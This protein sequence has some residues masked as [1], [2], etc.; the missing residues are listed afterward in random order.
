M[1]GAPLIE[2]LKTIKMP[3]NASGTTFAQ[4][5]KGFLPAKIDRGER[6]DN[7]G[8]MRQ[9]SQKWTGEDSNLRRYLSRRRT[10][11]GKTK[12]TDYPRIPFHALRSIQLVSS[13]VVMSIL[14]YFLWYLHHDGYGSPWTFILVS[15][16][17]FSSHVESLTGP[18]QK[19]TAFDRLCTH[20]LLTIGHNCSPHILWA[21]SPSQSVP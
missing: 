18:P 4:R 1:L 2:R 15:F 9:L 11:N 21:Q 20:H 7:P 17:R 19:K 8:L 5:F 14:S 6:G 13:I 10:S 16:P 3:G 12:P